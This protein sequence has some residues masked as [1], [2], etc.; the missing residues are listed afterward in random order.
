M[1]HNTHAGMSERAP[2]DDGI[3]N[4][5]SEIARIHEEFDKKQIS[6]SQVIDYLSWAK[7]KMDQVLDGQ[8]L[9]EHWEQTSKLGWLFTELNELLMSLC[10]VIATFV[11]NGGFNED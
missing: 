9:S 2:E 1:I 10:T 11:N 5:Y 7:Q 4:I 6:M 3:Q 8:E